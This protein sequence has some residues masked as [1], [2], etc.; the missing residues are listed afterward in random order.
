MVFAVDRGQD[1]EDFTEEFTGS[2]IRASDG[3]RIHG[4][5]TCNADVC[6]EIEYRFIRPA[7]R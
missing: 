6:T 2:Y 7:R 3:S 5:F 4:T 1:A